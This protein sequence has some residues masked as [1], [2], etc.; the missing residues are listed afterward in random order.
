MQSEN[1]AFFVTFNKNISQ[2]TIKDKTEFIGV[3][4]ETCVMLDMKR[5]REY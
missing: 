3:K 5:V 1:I 4:G 2:E